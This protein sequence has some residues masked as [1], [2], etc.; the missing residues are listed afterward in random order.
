MLNASAALR[1]QAETHLP[2]VLA[3]LSLYCRDPRTEAVLVRTIKVRSP[4]P[5]PRA[6]AAGATTSDRV[7]PPGCTPQSQILATYKQFVTLV[8]SEY[9][10]RVSAAVPSLHATRTLLDTAAPEPGGPTSAA[11]VGSSGT[12][13]ASVRTPDGSRP[14]SPPPPAPPA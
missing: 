2:L 5:R 14:P 12:S 10:V 6:D 7:G 13:S 4:A 3:K 11:A 1:T 8:Q 9:D